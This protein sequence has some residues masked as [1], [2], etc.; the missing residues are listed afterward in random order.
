[1]LSPSSGF[2]LLNAGEP[3]R[4]PVG[5]AMHAALSR[6]H[7]ARRAGSGAAQRSARDAHRQHGMEN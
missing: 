3:S 1:M 7:I 6:M 2:A 4:S 5:T